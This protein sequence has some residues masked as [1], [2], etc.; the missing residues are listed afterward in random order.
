MTSFGRR[1]RNFKRGGR[2]S[3]THGSSSGTGGNSF[4]TAGHSFG[5]TFEHSN[6]IIVPREE[7]PEI[8]R[9]SN[10]HSDIQTLASVASSSF[11]ENG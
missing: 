5:T 7:T 6:E 2:S 8:Q 10:E 1:W 4:G 9:Q 3:R 11:P